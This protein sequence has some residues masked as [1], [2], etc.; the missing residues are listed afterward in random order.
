MYLVS[1]GGVGWGRGLGWVCGLGV[2][3]GAWYGAG[4]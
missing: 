1:V 2:R 3:L 4:V